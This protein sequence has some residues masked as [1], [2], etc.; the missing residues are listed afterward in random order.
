MMKAHHLGL[1]V[2]D[3]GRSGRFYHDAMGFDQQ[4][5][6]SAPAKLIGQIFRR[7]VGCQVQVLQR[8]E[9]RLELFQPDEEMVDPESHPLSPG[10]NHFSFK[11]AD[12]ETFCHQAQEKGAEVI[13]VE[14]GDHIAYFIRDPDGILIEIKDD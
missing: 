8:D 2:R 6:Y 12:K 9:V 1:W 13:E 11:V 14:R 7:P 5:H 10:I 4:Y 3:L